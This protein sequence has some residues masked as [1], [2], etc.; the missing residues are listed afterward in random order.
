MAHYQDNNTVFTRDP[1]SKHTSIAYPAAVCH[2]A[3]VIAKLS[4]LRVEEYT[5]TDT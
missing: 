1:E 3:F 5:H 4:S 2:Y